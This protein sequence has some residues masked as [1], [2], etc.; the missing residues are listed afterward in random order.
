MP[1]TCVVARGLVGNPVSWV[2]W[3]AQSSG[4]LARLHTGSSPQTWDQ[5][6]GSPSGSLKM[7]IIVLL[8]HPTP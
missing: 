7:G 6:P 8:S 4:Q 1:E 2:G 3:E 5:N